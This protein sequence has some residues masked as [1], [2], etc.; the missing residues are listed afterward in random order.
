MKPKFAITCIILLIVVNL[1]VV[2]FRSCKEGFKVK[3]KE[4]EEDDPPKK[5]DPCI[6]LVSDLQKILTQIKNAES[7]DDINEL[8]SKYQKAY[9]A[10]SKAQ[11]DIPDIKKQSSSYI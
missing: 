11:C 8:T 9:N 5:K 3:K 4:D 10:A 2:Y 6:K 1:S 7:H